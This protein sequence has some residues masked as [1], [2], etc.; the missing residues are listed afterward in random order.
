MVDSNVTYLFTQQPD[1]D[2]KL[3]VRATSQIQ[4]NLNAPVASS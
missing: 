1:T 4:I 3:L 2:T